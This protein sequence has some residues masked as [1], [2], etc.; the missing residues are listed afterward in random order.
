[1]GAEG[2]EPSKTLSRQIYSLMRLATSL[3]SRMAERLEPSNDGADS[4][5]N[6]LK[7]ANPKGLDGQKRF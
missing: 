6:R 4:M 7:N 3:H 1:M 5:A 2:F